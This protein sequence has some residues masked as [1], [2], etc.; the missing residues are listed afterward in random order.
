MTARYGRCPACREYHD[1]T[2]I[3]CDAYRQMLAHFMPAS[4]NPKTFEQL[5]MR[6]E[7]A[8]RERAS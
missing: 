3:S 7:T 6:V 4:K 5:L 2:R 8:E 1:L